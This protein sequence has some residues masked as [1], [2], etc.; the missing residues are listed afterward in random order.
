MHSHVAGRQSH[1]GHG[2]KGAQSK[3]AQP[4]MQVLFA[5]V[6]VHCANP[7][8]QTENVLV[9][10]AGHVKSCQDADFLAGKDVSR[11]DHWVIAKL[12]HGD[13]DHAEK[14]L[15]E[16]KAQERI[17]LITRIAAKR[18]GAVPP[19]GGRWEDLYVVADS[20]KQIVRSELGTRPCL[21]AGGVMSLWSFAFGIR[22]HSEI[23]ADAI[24][25]LTRAR[26]E[27]FVDFSPTA[28]SIMQDA[29]ADPD[30]YEWDNPAAH[31]Q[32]GNDPMTGLAQPSD[33]Q[34]T[35]MLW[36]R[37][38]LRRGLE[39]ARA[40]RA[41]EALFF[42][43]YALHSVQDLASRRG[44]TN[45]EHEFNIRYE[46]QNPDEDEAAVAHAQYLTE[47][48]LEHIRAEFGVVWTMMSNYRQ[49]SSLSGTEKRRLIGHGWTIDVLRLRDRFH[50]GLLFSR[51]PKETREREMIRWCQL[52]QCDS[53][54]ATVWKEPLSKAQ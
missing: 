37:Q 13:Q 19:R 30:R 25:S 27:G 46:D 14:L 51:L 42:V 36:T 34:R 12:C 11:M 29:A 3:M 21:G 52:S 45:A 4:Q 18:L 22:G 50:Q 9:G 53:V 5:L 20:T 17:F 48:A 6:L 28:L 41:A 43:S 35:W 1:S 15:S 26:V 24:Q 7:A 32:T 2:P 8:V 54:L 10:A 49:G 31:A 40:G 16:L 47:R 44:R 23:I 39:A 38:Y 33:W